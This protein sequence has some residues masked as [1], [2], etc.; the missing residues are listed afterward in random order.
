VKDQIHQSCENRQGV[1]Q[2]K[3]HRPKT[4]MNH[5][6]ATLALGL[7]PRQGLMKVQAKCEGQ[8]SHFMLPAVQESVKE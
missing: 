5:I 3:Q 4:H 1:T 8:E 6:V 7:Q 2:P